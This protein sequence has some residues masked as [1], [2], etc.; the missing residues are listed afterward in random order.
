LLTIGNI[1]WIQTH[2]ED[3]DEEEIAKRMTEMEHIA[4]MQQAQETLDRE[5][6]SRK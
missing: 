1:W 4:N 2:V 3:V 6:R 5:L